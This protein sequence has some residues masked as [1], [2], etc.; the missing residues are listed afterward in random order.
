M[1]DF[2]EKL[3]QEFQLPLQ[4]P[5]LAFSLILLIILLSPIL[6]RKLNIPGIIGLIVSGVIIGPHGFNILAQSSAVD[7]FSTIGLLYIMFIAGLELDLSEFKANRNKSIGFGI[8]TFVIPLVL[9]YPI[10][11]Y[12]LGY[13]FNAAFLTASMFATHTLVAYPIVSNMGISKNQA[14][15]ITVGGTIFT[16]TAVLII[17]AIIVANSQ[18]SLNAEFWLRMGISFAIF[19]AIVFLVIPRIAQWFFKK[20]EDE[21]YSH[22][23]FVLAVVFFCAFLAEVA[24]IESIIG[25][26][27]AGLA[28]NSLIPHSGALMN[29]IEFIGNSLFIPFFLISVGMLVDISVIMSGPTAWIVAGAL[30]IVAIGGKWIA[31]WVTQLVY[32]YSSGQRGLIFGLSGAHAA[33]TLAVILVG[34]DRGI[35]DDNILNG[36]V[37][38]ILLASV[39]ATFATERAAKKVL[40]DTKE[41]TSDDKEVNGTTSE[42]LLIPIANV[43]NIGKLLEFSILIKNKN[44]KDPVSVLSVVSNDNEAESNIVR[45]RT[46]LEEIVRQGSATETDVNIL[47]AIDHEVASGI[48]RVSKEVLADAIIMMWPQ[49]NTP[50]DKLDEI[51]TQ[52][53]KT[54]F[55]GDFKRA[56]AVH[57]RTFL[58]APPYAELE[59]GFGLWYTKIAKLSQELSAPIELYADQRTIKAVEL[60]HKKNKFTTPLRTHEFDDWDDI[61]I[62]SRDIKDSDM[63]VIASS[64]KEGLSHQR[65]F[66]TL[67]NKLQKYFDKISKVIIYPQQEIHIYDALDYE[68]PVEP[69]TKSLERIQWLS[70]EIGQIF[71]KKE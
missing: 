51:L 58:V 34:H 7:W 59:D 15:A 39:I 55:V 36:T 64:R 53:S 9:G 33:A 13:D 40:A 2:F 52:I 3:L 18:G 19:L 35:I 69:L 11:H 70:K 4:S 41:N 61:L 6:L 10:V 56:L 67:P 24:G 54:I 30:S 20:L 37:I 45:A 1:T 62:L 71:K 44:S 16:D 26:F 50:A 28:L 12:V 14:V 65:I 42:H 22:Y 23:I 31:A 43:E 27:G 68:A 38:L 66:D 25:A 32:K 46:E 60:Y 57:K 17:L 8:F 48:S 47:T 63:L 21:R 49:K 29:R 5:I